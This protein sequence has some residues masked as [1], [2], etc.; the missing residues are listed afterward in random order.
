MGKRHIFAYNV[1]HSDAPKDAPGTDRIGRAR[2]AF[3]PRTDA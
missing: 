1:R 3:M 2:D